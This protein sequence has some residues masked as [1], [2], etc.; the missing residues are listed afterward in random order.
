MKLSCAGRL[1]A[2]TILSLGIAGAADAGILWWKLPQDKYPEHGLCAVI[3]SNPSSLPE[4]LAGSRNVVVHCIVPDADAVERLNARVAAAGLGGLVT[5]EALPLAR[6]PYR[7]NMLNELIV[8]D[9]KAATAAGLT[10]AEMARVIAPGGRLCVRE[11]FGWKVSVRIRPSEMDEWTHPY[12]GP[13]GGWVSNDKVVAFPLG[14]RW[15]DGLPFNLSIGI[16]NANAWTTTRGMAVSGGRCFTMNTS[17]QENLRR[18]H[19]EMYGATHGQDMFLT[20]RDAWNGVLLWRKKLGDLYYGGLHAFN[21]S[22]LVAVNDRVYTVSDGQKLIV[23]DAATGDLAA[24]YDTTYIPGIILVDQDTVV[25]ATWK[26]GSHIGP[27]TGVDRRILDYAV[28]EGTVEGFDAA[29]GQKLWST[30]KLATSLRSADGMLYLIQRDGP[31][32]YAEKGTGSRPEQRLIALDLRTGRQAWEAGSNELALATNEHVFVDAAGLGAVTVCHDNGKRISAFRGADG[33]LLF[34][35]NSGSYSAISEGKIHVGGYAYDPVTGTN[36]GPSSIQCGTTICTPVLNVNGIRIQNRGCGFVDHGKPARFGAARGACM[37]ASVPANGAFYTPQTWCACAPGQIPG[38]ISFGP[39]GRL[40][41]PAEMEQAPAVDKGPAL[42]QP[43][44]G[45][46]ADGDWPMFRHGPDR[47]AATPALAPTKLNVQWQ[48]RLAPALPDGLATAS[49]RDT[50]LDPLSAPV[51]AEGIVAATDVHRHQVVALDAASGRELWR[52]TVGGRV[53]TPPTIHQGLCLFGSHDG[54]IYALNARDGRLAWRMRTAPE[55]QRMVSYGQVESPWPVIGS[56]LVANGTAYASAGRTTESDGGIVVRAFDPASG[57]VRWSRAIGEGARL[58]DILYMVKGSVG[59]LT[60][61]FDPLTGQAVTDP[62]VV[63]ANLPQAAKDKQPRPEGL[64]LDPG[65]QGFACGHWRKLGSRRSGGA[66]FD[67]VAGSLIA[68]DDGVVLCNAGNGAAVTAYRRAPGACSNFWSHA[69]PPG[70]QVTATVLAANAVII[71]GG[72][73]P[74]D[75]AATR[76]FVR[77]LSRA[78]GKLLSEA[79]FDAPLVYDAVAVAGGKI[80]A[81]FADGTAA[82]MGEGERAAP[83]VAA[84]TT[85]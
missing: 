47:A 27:L 28:A 66:R 57:A 26:D 44:G 35:Q 42:G 36:M 81:T 71:G 15:H 22:P 19:E 8:E 61:R 80:Y 23:L 32:V 84:A 17:E 41:T 18:T 10:P 56:V 37:W 52:K 65:P 51:A 62:S 48:Q 54:Y 78:D 58:N 43:A 70:Y 64:A 59:L 40:P 46:A 5:V 55:D 60:L 72:L 29:T 68:W 38:F 21:R 63:Y 49:W 9:L 30:P 45:G 50:L 3:S 20:A 79:T 31:D 85:R 1:L 4:R 67:N 69:C 53:V 82:C 7:D 25:A 6:L 13:D 74:K 75:T 34:H 24:T 77:V 14:L 76:G 12:H 39:V 33:K 2:V 16:N 73:Y 83:L 11:G